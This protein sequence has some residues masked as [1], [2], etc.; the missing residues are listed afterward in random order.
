MPAAIAPHRHSILLGL[1]NFATP[2]NHVCWRVSRTPRL[3]L[4]YTRFAC[5]GRTRLP[6]SPYNKEQF[7][8][9]VLKMSRRCSRQSG[10]LYARVCTWQ[11]GFWTLYHQAQHLEEPSCSRL[12]LL[13]CFQLHCLHFSGP[14]LSVCISSC[15]NSARSQLLVPVVTFLYLLEGHHHHNPFAHTHSCRWQ[16]LRIKHFSHHR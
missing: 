4:L 1:Q 3:P 14:P 6:W 10:R 13:Y 12:Q 5:R 9:P 7:F 11:L 2:L 16:K 15:L 8:G